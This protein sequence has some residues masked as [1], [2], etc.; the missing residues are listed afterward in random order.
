MNLTGRIIIQA[1]VAP[2]HSP[3]VVVHACGGEDGLL[4]ESCCLKELLILP[5]VGAALG[6]DA[7]HQVLQGLPLHLLPALWC[8]RVCVCECKCVFSSMF[9]ST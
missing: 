4:A 6:G 9:T 3:V 5:T 8:G 1:G 7:T 2:M